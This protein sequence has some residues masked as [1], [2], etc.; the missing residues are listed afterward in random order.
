MM[1]SLRVRLALGACLAIGLSLLF[2]WYSLN[3]FFTTHVANTTLAE[4]TA[5][6]DSLAAN[7]QI[8][9][10]VVTLESQPVDPRLNL[11]AGGRY[12]QVSQSGQTPVRSRSLWDL[13]IDPAKLKPYSDPRLLEG[14]GPD[15]MP[16]LV[17]ASNTTLG[18]GVDAK[19]FVIYTALPRFEVDLALASFDSQLRAM[20]ILTAIV[21]AIAAGL[22][23]LLGL[24]PLDRLRKS[25][26]D[27]RSGIR[28]DLGDEGPSE[29]GPLVK[30]I[31]LLLAER[32]TAVERARARASDLAHGLKTPLT[33]LTQLAEMLDPQA[34][35]T[36]L[37]QVDLIRQRSDRQL[38]AARLGVEQMASTKVAEIAGKLAKVL[39]PLMERRDLSLF[40]DIPDELLVNADPADLAEALGNILDNA[41]KWA[42]SGVSVHAR[43]EG[44]MVC[45][46]IG[47][48]GPGMDEEAMLGMLQRGAHSPDSEGGSGLGW[49]FPVILPKPMAGSCLSPGPSPVVFLCRSIF[50]LATISSKIQ[51][52]TEISTIRS[53]SFCPGWGHSAKIQTANSCA[54]FQLRL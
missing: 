36:A 17:L 2:V 12:W 40:F 6:S 25:V 53:P 13:V 1:R 52:H 26:A 42:R 11:P 27:I 51:Y 38:Q 41:V 4:L 5:L 32:A 29:V 15:G 22:Q 20:L 19:S 30:E 8:V 47:D 28:A 24:R 49:Q 43:V 44:E 54:W 50:R 3:V 48:D 14:E 34:R 16:M 39:R 46:T 10:G 37:Q 18:E 35:D 9:D 33:V 31:N 7:A 23:S 45:I 21:L